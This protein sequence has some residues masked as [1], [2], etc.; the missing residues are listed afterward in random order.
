MATVSKTLKRPE[1][2]LSGHICLSSP[3]SILI[4]FCPTYSLGWGPSFVQARQK[5]PFQNSPLPSLLSSI[6]CKIVW[7]SQTCLPL[8][9]ITVNTTTLKLGCFLKLC[10]NNRPDL[11]HQTVKLKFLSCLNMWDRLVWLRITKKSYLYFAKRKAT[12]TNSHKVF[13]VT[14]VFQKYRA[15]QTRYDLM[16][17]GNPIFDLA[18]T[19]VV[20]SPRYWILYSGQN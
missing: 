17:N 20:L 2:L 5:I 9:A 11:S 7:T 18:A 16:C 3:F 6:V 15:I 8:G 4:I 1:D 13:T 12:V 10:K 19:S 14:I